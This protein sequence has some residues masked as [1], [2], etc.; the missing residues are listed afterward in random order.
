MHSLLSKV[1]TASQRKMYAHNY[2]LCE[3]MYLHIL[4]C[5]AVRIPRC[6]T[7]EDM[8]LCGYNEDM[9]AYIFLRDVV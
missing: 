9:C 7:E 4:L 5:D 2:I 3:D 6:I 8:Y 1:Y